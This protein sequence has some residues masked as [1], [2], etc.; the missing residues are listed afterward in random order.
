MRSDG[1]RV[2]FPS[3]FSLKQ[4]KGKNIKNLYR[5]QLFAET[6]LHCQ[7]S[8]LASNIK[9]KHFY[10]TVLVTVKIEKT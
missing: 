5:P 4:M 1:G 10:S 2:T 7:F 9:S 6:L 8:L 3:P